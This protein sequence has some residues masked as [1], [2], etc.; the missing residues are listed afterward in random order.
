MFK[1]EDGQHGFTEIFVVD[2][3]SLD[4][5]FHKYIIRDSNEPT[6]ILTEINFQKGPVK[7]YGVNGIFMEDLL[8][9][10]IHRLECFQES[11]IACRENALALTKIEEALQ[12][13]DNRTRNRRK[14]NVEGTN[15]K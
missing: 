3:P 12:W 8:Q 2:E 14:R 11:E 15:Q 4:K 7:E 5:S 6:R 13:L 1:L 10:C 9:I